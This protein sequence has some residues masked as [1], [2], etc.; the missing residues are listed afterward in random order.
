MN[1]DIW[2]LLHDGTITEITGVVP[3]D[4]HLAIEIGYLRERFPD[5]GDRIGLTLHG[6][7][8]FRYQLLENSPACSDP[9]FPLTNFA[10]IAS[11]RPEI[12]HAKDWT[13]PRVVE[14]SEGDLVLSAD[15]FSLALDNGRAISF[16]D[17]S[18]VAEAYWTAFAKNSDPANE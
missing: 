2:N 5:P 14:C 10:A 8:S 17:L 9:A 3:G 11:N 13:N 15:S 16:E 7:T 6:C 18:Q 1:A 4:V 12:R